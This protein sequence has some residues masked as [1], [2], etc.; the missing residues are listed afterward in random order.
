MNAGAY[1]GEM[2]QCL[3]RVWVLDE[4]GKVI[5]IPK[6]ELELGYRSKCSAKEG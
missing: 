4:D 3:T 1:D 2:K 5:Q 6:D